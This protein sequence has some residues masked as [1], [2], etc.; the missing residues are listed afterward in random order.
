MSNSI[1]KNSEGYSDY[2]A[3]VAIRRADKP[4]QRDKVVSNLIKGVKLIF[5]EFDFELT[6]RIK[7]RDIKTGKEYK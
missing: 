2:T 1:F 4:T 6:E 7:V 5:K 3:G